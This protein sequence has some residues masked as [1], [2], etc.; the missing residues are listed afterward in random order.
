MSNDCVPLDL[1]LSSFVGTRSTC[2]PAKTMYFS[3]EK[4][5][6]DE[7]DEAFSK[8]HSHGAVCSI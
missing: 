4:S 6:T 2:C 7:N 8:V 3:D 5:I 1:T